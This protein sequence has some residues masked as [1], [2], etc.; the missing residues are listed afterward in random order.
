M[1]GHRCWLFEVGKSEF[2][3][4]W[5]PLTSVLILGVKV[6]NLL[7]HTKLTCKGWTHIKDVDTFNEA[8]S[9]LRELCVTYELYE[10]CVGYG[11]EEDKFGVYS[12][13]KHPVKISS[14]QNPLTSPFFEPEPAVA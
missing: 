7:S 3:S 1:G 9:C 6:V 14:C 8:C 4:S 5:W 13:E 11:L 2:E 10:F 12:R